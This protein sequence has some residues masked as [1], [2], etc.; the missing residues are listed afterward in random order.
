MNYAQLPID[1]VYAAAFL[2]EKA[3][4]ADQSRKPKVEIN[5]IK[6]KI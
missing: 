3:D 2:L 4:V 5:I 1:E 6:N